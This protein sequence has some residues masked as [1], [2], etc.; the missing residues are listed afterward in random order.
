MTTPAGALPAD[1]ELTQGW[2]AQPSWAILDTD[3]ATLAHF[4]DAWHTWQRAP[5]RPRMLHYV[6]VMQE[7]QLAELTASAH[8]LCDSEPDWRPLWIEFA[9]LLNS[10]RTGQY[11]LLLQGGNLSLT[12]CIAPLAEALAEQRLYADTV[13][14]GPTEASLDVWQLKALARCCR[15]GARMVAQGTDSL[16]TGLLAETGFV[17]VAS[18]QNQTVATFNPPWPTSVRDAN[19][20]SEAPARCVVV[21]AGL[22]GASVAQTLALRGWQVTVLD[23]QA[24][25]AEGASGLPVGLVVPHRSA[26]DS[27]RSRLS[28]VGA[29]LMLQ[30]AS[31][32]LKMGYDWDASGVL[33]KDLSAQTS[34]W[35]SDAAWIRPAQLVRTWLQQPNIRCQFG[36]TVALLARGHGSWLLK[37]ADGRLLAEAE[38]VVFANA[39]ASVPLLLNPENMKYL[40]EG[41]AERLATLHAVHGTVSYAPH[42]ASVAP[43]WP[44]HP[45]NGHGYFV[46]QVPLHGTSSWLAGSTFEPDSIPEQ[47]GH[48]LMPLA[49]QHRANA[50]RLSELLP[51]VAPDLADLFMKGHVQHWSSTRCVSHDRLP[52][53]GPLDDEHNPTL[54]LHTALGARGLSFSALGAEL[55]AA[56]LGAEPLP[57]LANLARSLDLRR[58]KRK[59]G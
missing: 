7:P 57:I 21:G 59:R 12:L 29:H 54:W 52:L 2:C 58:P 55:L 5:L 18:G 32:L 50:Q 56:R 30:H 47:P 25:A 41:V 42:Q 1:R 6:G 49:D 34:H 22:A 10:L 43:I 35:H 28:R 46:P 15:R 53:V 45:V 33:E 37:D 36:R 14:L 20:N 9:P 16:A 13:Y 31:K 17:D 8:A 23:H 19:A 4:L 26:D 39:T 24:Q 27:P 51:E 38:Q 48:G 44:S 11:R 3:F 40:G